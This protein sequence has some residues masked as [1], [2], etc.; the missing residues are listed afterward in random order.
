[1]LAGKGH[2]AAPGLP[3][4]TELDL[5]VEP[6]FEG[7]SPL[8]CFVEIPKQEAATPATNPSTQPRCGLCSSGSELGL[9]KEHQQARGRR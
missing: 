4:W 1:M 6:H 3:E 2:W 5:D 9:S 7:A 8:P